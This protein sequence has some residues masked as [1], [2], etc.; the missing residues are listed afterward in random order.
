MIFNTISQLNLVF[1]FLFFGLICGFIATIYFAI[2]LKNYNKNLIKIINNCIF[3]C[4]FSIFYVFLIIF[5]NFGKFS[6]TLAFAYTAGFIWSTKL[7]KKLLVIL[8]K[9]CYTIFKKLTKN[10]IKKTKQRKH[11]SHE[12]TSKN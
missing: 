12:I 6:A 9:R 5:F 1:I 4:F 7:L 2:T 11:K 3:Y 10:F 8:E